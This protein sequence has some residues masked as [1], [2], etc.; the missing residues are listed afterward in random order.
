MSRRTKHIHF[1]NI[2]LL[3]LLLLISVLTGCE[4]Q[5]YDDA[6]AEEVSQAGKTIIQE[7]LDQNIPNA[8]LTSYRA[9]TFGYPGNGP[10]YLNGYVSGSFTVGEEKTD[11][12]VSTKTG[13]VYLSADLD[14]FASFAREYILSA[15]GFDE[16]KDTYNYEVSL[17]LPYVYEGKSKSYSSKD[18]VMTYYNLPAEI[19]LLLPEGKEM[20][21]IPEEDISV[22]NAYINQA[23]N[24]DL[25]SVYIQ[26]SV[27]DDISLKKYDLKKIKEIKEK[28]GLYFR[29]YSF[30]NNSE[31]AT[32]ADWLADYS[33][34]EWIEL[35]EWNLTLRAVIE[36]FSDS[37]D[38]Q[39]P[40]GIKREIINYTVDD[41]ILSE[42]DNGFRIAY[43]DSDKGP[44]FY[45]YA[46]EGSPLLN[47]KYKISEGDLEQYLHWEHDDS[48]DLWALWHEDLG[49]YYFYQ[50][51]DLVKDE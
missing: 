39:A 41:I 1:L 20:S 16:L 7:W 5:K 26:G 23:A 24:R 47:H 50:P 31:H 35:P 19:A 48:L 8:E 4:S 30:T 29:N 40:D 9:D 14:L 44:A 18:R 43:K 13:Q 51:K 25:L 21:D 12:T 37:T 45:M 32:G 33:R 28:Y 3:S 22:I 46:K 11:F 6:E 36:S 10:Y 49:M 15:L 42:T 38:N 2:A 27:S 34:Q 17:E